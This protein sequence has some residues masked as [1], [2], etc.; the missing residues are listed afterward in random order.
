VKVA[1]IALSVRGAMG[2]YL[3]AFVPSL[4]RQTEVHLFV[5]THYEGELGEATPHRFA[6]GRTRAKALLSFL[7]PWRARRVW[8]EVKSLTPNIVHL[9]N[10]EGYPWSLRFA[11]WANQDHIPLVVTVHDPEPHS[12]NLTETLNA[13]LRRWVIARASCVHIH[14][15]R[16]AE[17]IIKR[18]VAP[19]RINVIPHGSLAG[20]FLRHRQEGISREKLA[21]FFGRLEAYKGL[22]VLTKA[23]LM[24]RGQM[25]IAIAGPG[26][27][28]R[29]LQKVIQSHT[30]IFELQNRYLQDREVAILLQRASVCVLP[31]RQATQSSVPLIAAAFGVPVV[32]SAIGAF[33]DD[34]PRVNGLLV[35][36]ND[37]SALTQGILDARQKIPHYPKDLEFAILSQA[38]VK[39][40]LDL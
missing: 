26:R 29:S 39:M 5:P 31:Y 28:P 16:F 25:R 21:L 23:G 3:E 8:N 11:Q 37:P 27:L 40:Y 33:V 10:G 36:P 12:A 30:D 35:P 17:N 19:K 24:L 9:F 22:D 6:T 38:Y 7:N 1:I 4:S 18:G 20:R 14:N 15:V 32:A 13:Y 2:Q 34:V